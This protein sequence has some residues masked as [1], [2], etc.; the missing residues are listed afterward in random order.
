MASGGMPQRWGGSQER[1]GGWSSTGE[2]TRT[3]MMLHAR[4][5]GGST[6]QS[7]RRL[8]HCRYARCR[9]ARCWHGGRAKLVERPQ[10]EL[11]CRNALGRVRA[12]RPHGRDLS[13]V[14]F[15]GGEGHEP[16][17]RSINL[18]ACMSHPQAQFG[19]GRVRLGVAGWFAWLGN[20]A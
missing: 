12:R 11:E 18:F 10:G 15:G 17:S 5:R 1:L 16:G 13:C 4:R 6:P 7:T 8:D 20:N 2:S 14:V 9:Y 3:M 19:S